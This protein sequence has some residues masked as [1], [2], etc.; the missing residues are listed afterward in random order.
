MKQKNKVVCGMHS[1]CILM[2]P[3][4]AS[5]IHFREYGRVPTEN[6]QQENTFSKLFI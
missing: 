5:V 6:Y 3:T 1:F 4:R 2:K